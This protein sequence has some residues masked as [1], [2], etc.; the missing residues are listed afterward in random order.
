M[1][2]DISDPSGALLH[3]INITAAKDKISIK[4]GRISLL[5]TCLDSARLVSGFCSIFR[6]WSHDYGKSGTY[7]KVCETLVHIPVDFVSTQLK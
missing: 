3:E 4:D 7:S 1:L 6:G 2:L 5:F